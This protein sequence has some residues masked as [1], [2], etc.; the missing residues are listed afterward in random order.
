MAYTLRILGSAEVT[1]RTFK[2]LGGY[3]YIDIQDYAGGTWKLQ[4]RVID[5]TE[6]WNDI[7]DMTFSG[8]ASRLT[9]L[10]TG[11]EYQLTGGMVGAIGYLIP[12]VFNIEANA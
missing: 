2:G 3:C 6:T 9:I 12:I 10:A 7:S 8:N 4:G 1:G 11:K 5:T